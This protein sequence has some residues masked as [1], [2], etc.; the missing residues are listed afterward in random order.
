MT[1]SAVLLA[2]L[3]EF[4]GAGFQDFVEDQFYTSGIRSCILSGHVDFVFE[5][6]G[7]KFPS[8]A[9]DL[10]G[11]LL[12]PGHYLDIDRR[13]VEPGLHMGIK[14]ICG[15]TSINAG[16]CRKREE[17]WLQRMDGQQFRKGLVICGVGHSL[18]FAFRLTNAGYDV[19]LCQHLPFGKLCR[20][21]HS[22]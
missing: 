4:Q 11:S 2:T 7:G 16:E 10:A 3:H 6:A 8:I 17:L 20:R 13:E 18:S 9:Q 15:F 12:T 1:R 19:E 14:P 21:E 5:E 22:Q